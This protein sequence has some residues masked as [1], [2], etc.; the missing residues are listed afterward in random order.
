MVGGDAQCD[1]MGHSAKYGSYTIEEL[2]EN[3]MID[4]ELVQV[5]HTGS[6]QLNSVN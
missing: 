2:M 3:K 5:R 1:S 4:L 6:L